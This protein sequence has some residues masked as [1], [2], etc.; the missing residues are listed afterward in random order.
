MRVRMYGVLTL[1]ALAGLALSAAAQ[2]DENRA[3]TT[4]TGNLAHAAPQPYTAEFRITRVQTL[5]DGSTITHKSTETVARDSQG[6]WMSATTTIPIS[7]DQAPHT[8]VNVSDPVAHTHS[9]WAVPGQR[10]MVV[11]LPGR[12]ASPSSCA[13]VTLPRALQPAE[14][15]RIESTTEDLGT[16]TYQGV[17]AKGRRTTRTIPAGEIGNSDQLIRTF[18]VWHSTTPGLEGIVVRQVSEDPLTGNMTRELVKLTPGEPDS[19]L[20]QPPQDYE[21]VTQEVHDEVRCPQ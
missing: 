1:A 8:N 2:V 10:A 13:A 15:E 7:E 20:F 18:E 21:V 19:A 11:N 12:G 17:E 14:S 4:T 16:R 6:R 9:S 5:A 3:K